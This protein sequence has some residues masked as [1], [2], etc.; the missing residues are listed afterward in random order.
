MSRRELCLLVAMVLGPSTARAHFFGTS[1]TLP[2]PFSLYAYGASATLIITFG[3]LVAF[4]AAAFS[5]EFRPSLSPY[6]WSASRGTSR[7]LI[8]AARWIGVGFLALITVTALLGSKDPLSNIGSSLFWVAIGLGLT[9]LSAV[10]GGLYE[11]INPWRA[12]CEMVASVDA[13]RLRRRDKHPWK[14]DYWP[15]VV[16]FY[17][18]VWTELFGHVSPQELGWILV[19]YSVLNVCCAWRYGCDAW[20]LY[21]ELFGVFFGVISR[22]APIL[23]GYSDDGRLKVE[24]RWPFADVHRRSRDSPSLVFIVL[25]I[26][27]ATAFDG[28]HESLIW[29]RIFWKYVYPVLA[30][31]TEVLSAHPLLIAPSLFYAWQW[32]ML[33]FA[34]IIYFGIFSFCI[35]LTR[36]A[37]D[38]SASLSS[39]IVPF[40]LTVIPIGFVYHFS[41]YLG[42]FVEQ[43]TRLPRLLWN[44]LMNSTGGETSAP[45]IILGASLVWHTQVCVILA[46]HAV[47]VYL[48][49]REAVRLWSGRGRI[50]LSQLPMLVLMVILTVM[51]LWILSLPIVT[52]QVFQPIALRPK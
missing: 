39:L 5:A 20:F 8:G 21:G 19:G 49:H 34:P 27:A 51:G 47:G 44:L 45:G 15:A 26:L 17:G 35:W 12:L 43:G 23:I 3:L 25:F 16:L 38:R 2:I 10:I 32:V 41:H 4:P 1:Y 40:A 24:L 31:I 33:A 29:V 14:W 28:L 46:G 36:L 50:A 37:T 11:L 30:P 48:S 22:I 7:A 13:R 52:G 9:Y 42:L 6:R 18:Y